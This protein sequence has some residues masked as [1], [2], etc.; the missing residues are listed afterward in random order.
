MLGTSLPVALDRGA[1][2]PGLI[3][4]MLFIAFGVGATKATISPLI[5]MARLWVCFNQD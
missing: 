3:V 2:F 5:G 4:A 1:G